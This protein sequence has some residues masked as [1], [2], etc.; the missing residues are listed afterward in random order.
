[1]SASHHDDRSLPPPRLE[2]V[3]SGIY[4]YIQPDGSWWINNT[5]FLAGRRGV[6]SIDACS[7]ERRTR[8]YRRAIAEVTAR[9]I[10]TLI[11]THHHGDHTFGNYL[12]PEATIVAHERTRELILAEGIPEYRTF[13]WSPDVE[14]GHLEA[15]APFLTYSDRVT[16]YSDDLRCE[17]RHVG[18]AAHTTN[19]SYV[20]IPERRLLFA[21]DLAFNGGTPFV[22]MGSV[23]GGIE[24]LDQ[25]KEL[26]AETV[27]P[28]HGDV[29]GPEVFD[30]VRGYLEFVLVTAERGKA[31]GLTPLEAARE[32]DLGEWGELLDA[33]RIVGNLHRAY[34]ELDGLPRGGQIDLVAAIT[35][36]ITFNGG[37]PLSC[38]A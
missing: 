13:A 25:L 26:G 37:K 1:M 9:P 20:W 34:A 8:T 29:C 15:V 31:A 38:L 23:T 35:D 33:E 16:V 19:D 12:F 10:T 6:I 28:G 7:T 21:G 17:V 11:N 27:V 24:A 14:W 18:F 36:M 2:E 5:G 3:S 30:Q 32:T 22:L 4:A